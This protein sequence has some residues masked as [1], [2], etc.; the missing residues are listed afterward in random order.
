MI[1]DVRFLKYEPL[2]KP[3]GFDPQ[4]VKKYG[5]PFFADSIK[6]P[7]CVGTA[8]WEEFWSREVDRCINGYDAGNGFIINGRYYYYLNH[9][10][11]TTV[12]RG[13]HLPEFVDVD[14]EFSQL[15]EE[16]KAKKKG[17][18]GLK[19]R[20]RG[21]SEKVVNMEIDY[22]LRFNFMGYQAAV[23]AGLEKYVLDFGSKLTSAELN[24]YPELRLNY[25][26]GTPPEIVVGYE[27][28]TDQG[29]K[30]DGSFSTVKLRTMNSDPNVLKGTFL[31]AAIFEESGENGLLIEGFGATE[32]S[33]KMGDEMIG[34]PYV[35]G[36]GGNIKGGSKG[37]M[38]M[39]EAAEDFNLIKCAIF[40]QRLNNKY[41]WGSRS[42]NG[43]RNDS[44]C[45]N[46]KKL[47]E[48]LN[49][50]DEQ[51]TG[52]EDIKASLESIESKK[53]KLKRGKSLKKYFD[54]LQNWATNEKEAFL[55]LNANN[56]NSIKISEQDLYLSSLTEL[57]YKTYRLEW[58][59][60]KSGNK[61]NP[62]KVKMIEFD[63]ADYPDEDEYI[64]IFA[65]PEPQFKNL[66][67]AGLDG[68]DQD[69][70]ATSKSLGSM[71]ILR[72]NA[73]NVYGPRGNSLIGKKVPVALIRCR[74]K[75][76]E[77]FF[78][79][80]AK[81]M[82]LYGLQRK[83]MIDAGSSRIVDYLKKIG[84]V[85]MLAKRPRK[86]E[87]ANSK[88]THEY[89]MK[90]TT[91]PESKKQVISLI[92]SYTDDYVDECVFPH[93]IN[94]LAN[95]DEV[96]TDND[97]D[98]V[99]ALGL[100]LVMDGEIKLQPERATEKKKEE[101][102]MISSFQEYSHTSEGYSEIKNFEGKE[103][104]YSDTH[105]TTFSSFD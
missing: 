60:D 2:I 21:M 19:S 101:E 83:V 97:W 52:C 71:L 45:T 50:S 74:P 95:Y 7:S 1:S 89:G 81:G 68:Y 76:K 96:T 79:L 35:Y 24:R 43:E 104:N 61:L 38:E 8:L 58:E 82:V 5:I 62:L 100:A 66:D 85:G 94:G 72:R 30:R 78:E 90:F 67:V 6:N 55:N 91:S 59:T 65:G 18:I 41:Y 54:F 98:E 86:Y 102:T 32:D 42:D 105:E 20:R 31:D 28:K 103:E 14:Y 4:P 16:A 34:T 84:L 56:F 9:C 80:C 63:L 48:E 46:L 13:K 10:L 70:S 17:I 49:L 69:L 26:S 39:W 51:L 44:K 3:K 92:Q 99:D 22:G 29:F 23:A 57:P 40:S 64:M 93:V 37:F 15:I 11:I 77:L 88:Q 53:L 73:Y 87:S 36:T 47:K 75:R 25:L 12:K 27:I 33:F